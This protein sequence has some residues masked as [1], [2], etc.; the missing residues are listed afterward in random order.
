MSNGQRKEVEIVFNNMANSG[1]LDYVTAWYKKAALYIQG[2]NIEVAFV[3]TNSICQGEQVL[4][5]WTE[6]LHKHG[7]KI[8]FAHH[9]FKWSNEARCNAAVYCVIIGLS[10][11]DRNVKK[12]YHYA[13]VS[14]LP[15]EVI[16]SQINAYLIDAPMIF[17]EKR[18]QPICNVSQMTKGSSPTDNGNFLLTEEE[19]TILIANDASIADLIRPFTGAKEYLHNIPRYCIWLKGVPPSKYNRSKEITARL[20]KI[21]AFRSKS[22]RKATLKYADIPSLFVEIRQPETNYIIIPRHSSENRQY[23]PI[24]FMDKNVIAGDATAFI[25]DAT[26]Y[27]FGIISSSMHMAWMRHTCGRIKSDYRYSNTLVYN[28]F[29]W[30][31]PTVKQKQNIEEAAQVVLNARNIYPNSSLADLYDTTA[32]LPELLKAHQKLDKAVEKA[33]GREFDNDTQRV[34]YLFE[35]YQKLSGELFKDEKKRGKGRKVK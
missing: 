1:T 18:S 28:N 26:I 6:L 32:I 22:E 2:T 21:K 12:L 33:Y 11:T 7:I 29:P 15:V 14:G 9:T 25:P 31:T 19:K 5:L 3:S 4:V 30:P 20:E 13:D 10:L 35:L 34:A 24:G 16:V 27:E 17:I 8:N 23:I